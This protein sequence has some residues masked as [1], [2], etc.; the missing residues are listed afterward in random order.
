MRAYS[1]WV[2]KENESKCSAASCRAGGLDMSAAPVET[3][4]RKWEILR[5]I[6]GKKRCRD[7]VWG[8]GR[9]E[10]EH[11]LPLL[12][13]GALRCSLS[14]KEECAWHLREAKEEGEAIKRDSPAPLSWDAYMDNPTNKNAKKKIKSRSFLLEAKSKQLWHQAVEEDELLDWDRQL[15]SRFQETRIKKS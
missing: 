4:A 15:F 11:R 8:S 7:R 1:C 9:G 10:S 3:V 14:R 5:E 12:S 13:R 6:M 2:L